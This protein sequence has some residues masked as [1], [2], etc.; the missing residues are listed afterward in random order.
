ME[1]SVTIALNFANPADA[2]AFL[3]SFNPDDWTAKPTVHTAR[4]TAE[5]V[6]DDPP[7]NDAGPGT[8]R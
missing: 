3:A 8:S 1:T 7:W 2:A 4:K 6:S 5:A